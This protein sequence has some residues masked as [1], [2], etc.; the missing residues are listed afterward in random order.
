MWVSISEMNGQVI[1]STKEM[2][3]DEAVQNSN[4]KL[5]PKDTTLLSFKLSIGKTAIAGSDLYT[6][7][8]IAALVPLDTSKILNEYIFI[9]FNSK[10]LD[11]ENVG[12]KAFGKSLNSKFLKES[13]PIPV[14]PI[15]IQKQIISE[16]DKL[17]KKYQNSR[18]MIEDYRKEIKNIFNKLGVLKIEEI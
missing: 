7:E 11:L 4:V 10:I 14:P 8:A 6:N 3:T 12:N 17:D 2:I 1:T 18:M 13:I 16:V 9:F 5:I 15:D